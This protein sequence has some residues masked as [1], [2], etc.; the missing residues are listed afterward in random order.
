ML[1]LVLQQKRM[2]LDIN[3]FK[4]DITT[5]YSLRTELIVDKP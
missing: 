3:T 5:T 4:M 2:I 1:L